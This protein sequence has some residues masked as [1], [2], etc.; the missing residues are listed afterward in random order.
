MHEVLNIFQEISN[1]VVNFLLAKGANIKL[2][3]KNGLTA[4]DYAK[5]NAKLNKTKLMKKLEV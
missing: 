4:Y 5:N 2:K 1:K 3:N